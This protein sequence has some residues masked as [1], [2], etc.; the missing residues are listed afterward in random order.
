MK[1]K[2]IHEMQ[3]YIQNKEGFSTIGTNEIKGL[4]ANV[5]WNIGLDT[6]GFDSFSDVVADAV[7]SVNTLIL[8]GKSV[9]DILR[10]DYSNFFF[11]TNPIKILNFVTNKTQ[12]ENEVTNLAKSQ[13][14]Y[15]KEVYPQ[16]E[17][18]LGSVKNE[19]EE[20]YWNNVSEVEARNI[21][22]R[23]N[24]TPEELRESI[25]ADTE[26][27]ERSNQIVEKG[28]IYDLYNIYNE[29]WKQ[30]KEKE[31]VDYSKIRLIKNNSTEFL[32]TVLSSVKNLGMTTLSTAKFKGM[33]PQAHAS[34]LNNLTNFIKVR[35]TSSME[36]GLDYKLTDFINE[37]KSTSGIDV[38]MK[39][40]AML[41][42]D[43]NIAG[44]SLDKNTA[45]NVV[46]DSLIKAGFSREQAVQLS[47]GSNLFD[48]AKAKNII[49]KDC[50]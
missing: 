16:L 50:A 31:A 45:E 44:S 20:V 40:A 48:Y 7:E 37:V 38:D 26:G 22:R 17:D 49:K 41:F 46:M 15:S 11:G 14:F 32:K 3:H 5:M 30:F 25:M 6:S 28:R 36:A 34:F 21:E 19:E 43:A 1:S 33:T 2:I 47:K 35:V 42:E 9:W 4:M 18:L 39:T 23:M 24:M 29:E 10:G 13:T 27:I 12:R 8:E